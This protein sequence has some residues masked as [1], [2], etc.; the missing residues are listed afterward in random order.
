MKRTIK[1]LFPLV[2]AAFACLFALMVLFTGWSGNGI[3]GDIGAGFSG[4]Q[5]GDAVPE[6]GTGADGLMESGN[7]PSLK[8]S[9]GTRE[10][11]S[12]IRLED[13]FQVIYPDG[14]VAEAASDSQMVIYF[15][16]AED[17]SGNS[18]AVCLTTQ[19]IADMEEITSPL[20]F[21]QEQELLYCHK[22]GIYKMYVRM[23]YGN[24]DGILMEF[25]MPVEAG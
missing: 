9:G 15:V 22:S 12:C 7:I 4:M 21:D 2:L 14:T 5:A 23:Y 19:E 11:G 6:F 8:Y 1:E 24:Y 16:D 25:S 17:S 18:T 10:T 13:L 20:I 3:F